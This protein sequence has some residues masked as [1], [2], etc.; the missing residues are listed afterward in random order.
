MGVKRI[1]AVVVLLGGFGCELEPRPR[2]SPAPDVGSG[3]EVEQDASD[4]GV[5]DVGLPPEDCVSL[6]PENGLGVGRSCL[7]DDVCDDA[8]RAYFCSADYAPSVAAATCT[9]PCGSDEEC[10]QEAFCLPAAGDDQS[11]ALCWPTRCEEEVK[12]P[13]G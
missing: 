13:G 2:P 3:G 12:R 10:G 9:F 1:A 11:V 4:T 5:V 6:G 8:S 7:D